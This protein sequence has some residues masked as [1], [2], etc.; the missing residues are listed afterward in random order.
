MFLCHSFAFK[1][2]ISCRICRF[3]R[4]GV[5]TLLCDWSWAIRLSAASGVGAQYG[6][7]ANVILA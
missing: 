5:V 7:R 1:I 4:P 3:L 2:L 6:A